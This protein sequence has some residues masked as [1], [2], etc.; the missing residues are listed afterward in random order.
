MNL[1]EANIIQNAALMAPFYSNREKKIN[2]ESK[3][4]DIEVSMMMKIRY[5]VIISGRRKDAE[6]NSEKIR[7]KKTK[8]K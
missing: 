5:Q 6:T 7:T 3:L 1:W 8:L 4:E 2:A